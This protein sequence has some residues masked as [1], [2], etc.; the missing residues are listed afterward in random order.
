MKTAVSIPD[1]VFDE[2]EELARRSNITRSELYANALRALLAQDRNITARL[3]E[4]YRKETPDPAFTAA[5][6][7]T[8]INTEW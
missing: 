6:R 3:D 1:D 2:A 5:A 7:R 8:F 4:I